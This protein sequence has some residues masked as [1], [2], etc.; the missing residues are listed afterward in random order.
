MLGKRI[1]LQGHTFMIRSEGRGL[2]RPKPVEC[3]LLFITIFSIC[4]YKPED[5]FP[6][7]KASFAH[8]AFSLFYSAFG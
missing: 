3:L 2:F 1:F 6:H 8:N 4:K 7:M 5:G